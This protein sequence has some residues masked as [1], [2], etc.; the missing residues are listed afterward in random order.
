MATTANQIREEWWSPSDLFFLKDALAR[1]MTY[2]EVAGFLSRGQAEVR[3]K[4]KQ[5]KISYRRVRH[6]T[7]YP[8][9][10]GR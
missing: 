1:G 5:L 8:I 9:R 10:R 2:V 3:K 7:H 4:A 6:Y